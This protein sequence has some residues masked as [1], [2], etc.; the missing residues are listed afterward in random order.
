ML[1][2]RLC[3]RSAAFTTATADN[4]ASA[5]HLHTNGEP[6]VSRT[7]VFASSPHPISQIRLVK[8]HYPQ[9]AA[10][11]PTSLDY[12]N[13]RC[14]LQ[15]MHHAF[16]EH[17]NTHFA[18][19]K[20]KFEQT[21]SHSTGKPATPAELSRFYKLY[22]HENS[23]R[24]WAYNRAWWAANAYLVMPAFKSALSFLSRAP[25]SSSSSVLPFSVSSSSPVTLL[26]PRSRV[27]F[28]SLTATVF[29]VGRS[30]KLLIQILIGMDP[31]IRRGAQGVSVR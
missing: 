13:R 3:L 24:H 6:T 1:P 30:L 14:E 11:S 20:A 17:N 29:T 10:P 2:S 4:I 9:A 8:Y 12:H 18:E 26:T 25:S 22:L 27:D 19:E 31:Q 5:T 7:T 15:R 21:V 23:Q 28:N 16:W